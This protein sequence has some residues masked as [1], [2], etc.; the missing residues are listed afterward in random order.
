[1]KLR[2]DLINCNTQCITCN[3]RHEMDERPYREWMLNTYGENTV[4]YFEDIGNKKPRLTRNQ[5]IETYKF[6]VEYAEKEYGIR[7]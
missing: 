7:T 4:E 3:N 5:K 6:L 1:M 2:W